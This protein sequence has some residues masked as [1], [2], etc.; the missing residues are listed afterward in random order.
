MVYA[1]VLGTSVA[2]LEGSSPSSSTMKKYFQARLSRSMTIITYVFVLVVLAAPIIVV[3][4]VDTLSSVQKVLL[5]PLGLVILLI[6][7]AFVGIAYEIDE[8]ELVV[9]R[10]IKSIHIPLE[11]IS[12]VRDVNPMDVLKG[13]MTWRLF[14]DGGLWGA[15][16]IFYNKNIGK[17]YMYMT[18]EKNV[19]DIVTKN[20]V[21]TFISPSPKED[22]VNSLREVINK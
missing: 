9:K 11:N 3:S 2:R 20:N 13:R 16:G 22:F 1:L 15:H 19:V 21:H 4:T 10:C 17:F 6:T 7:R 8:R 12:E 14:G 18:D 5:A